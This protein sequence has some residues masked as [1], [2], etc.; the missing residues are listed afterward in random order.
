MGH[1]IKFGLKLPENA[2][3]VNTDTCKSN[4]FWDAGF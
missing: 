4:Y 1:N 3:E 2:V